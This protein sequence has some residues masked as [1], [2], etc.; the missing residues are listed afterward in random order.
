VEPTAGAFDDLGDRP[1][2]T[3]R[4]DQQHDELEPLPA[5][6][7]DV[8]QPDTLAVDVPTDAVQPVAHPAAQG[9]QPDVGFGVLFVV[10]L[11]VRVEELQP[12]T[13]VP[14]NLVV[15]RVRDPAFQ[16]MLL[17]PRKSTTA[18]NAWSAD[19][20]TCPSCPG[21]PSWPGI[22]ILPSRVTRPGPVHRP[23]I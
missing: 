15:G 12:V 23:F 21:S 19:S 16:M 3:M 4:F 2:V 9:G 17:A 13:D 11:T 5:S 7:R 20:S 1:D 10:S 22:A 18:C 6:D 14:A 8:V